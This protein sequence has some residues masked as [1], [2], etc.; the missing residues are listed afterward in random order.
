MTSPNDDCLFNF[1]KLLNEDEKQIANLKPS[2]KF[3]IQKIDVHN[4]LKKYR[5]TLD[6]IESALKLS[7]SNEEL[8]IAFNGGKDCCLVLYLYYHLFK[9]YFQINGSTMRKMNVLIMELG[10]TQFQEVKNFISYLFGDYYSMKYINLIVLKDTIKTLKECLIDFKQM[11][12][13]ILYILM[14]TRRTDNEYVKNLKEFS[15]TDNNW[16]H[17]IRVNPLLDWNYSEVWY[18]LIRYEIPYCSLYDLGYTSLGNPN[19]TI[20]NED[21]FDSNSNTYKPAYLLE[22]ECK[23]RNSRI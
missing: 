8:C 22:N 7:T 6:T 4:F 15:P 17:F 11:Y 3:L 23:E 21:L 10:T 13:Q 18:F 16:P 20:K 19:K 5:H 2:L 1:E 12:P 9:H 14:G